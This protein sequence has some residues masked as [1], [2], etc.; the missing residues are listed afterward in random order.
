MYYFQANAVRKYGN[1]NLESARRYVI[2]EIRSVKKAFGGGHW[3]IF[4][5]RTEHIMLLT[6]QEQMGE[7]MREAEEL[8]NDL[9]ESLGGSHPLRLHTAT[10]LASLYTKQYRWEDAVGILQATRR[11]L[12]QALGKDHMLAVRAV[13]LLAMMLMNQGKYEEAD[14]EFGSLSKLAEM[15]ETTRE[16][17]RREA[18]MHQCTLLEME[19]NF[20][21]AKAIRVTTVHTNGLSS[22]IPKL[23]KNTNQGWYAFRREDFTLAESLLAEVMKK[24]NDLLKTDNPPEHSQLLNISMISKRNLALVIRCHHRYEAAESL[25]RELLIERDRHENQTSLETLNAMFDLAHTLQIQERWAEAEHF[26]TKVKID[27]VQLFG[28]MHRE[29]TL[30]C[31]QRLWKLLSWNIVHWLN[32]TVKAPFSEEALTQMIAMSRT[33]GDFYEDSNA[34][35]DEDNG[36]EEEGGHKPPERAIDML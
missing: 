8:E 10:T 11:A 16:M 30:L 36:E 17:Y 31:S 12:V 5:L 26:F 1:L 13:G 25:Q 18:G 29:D 2:H 24:A 32:A 3:L 20:H 33:L 14:A 15:S 28:Q 21:E 22:E 4:P 23:L 7:A 35:E 34:A 19:G 27:R 6:A 9:R